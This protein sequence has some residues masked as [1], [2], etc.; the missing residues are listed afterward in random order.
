MF[1]PWMDSNTEDVRGFIAD[2]YDIQYP[3]VNTQS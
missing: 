2:H 1:A 3:V